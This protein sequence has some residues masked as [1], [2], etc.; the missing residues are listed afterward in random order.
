MLRR[1][2]ILLNFLLLFELSNACTTF[3]I[4]KNGQLVFGRNYD[5]ISGA[6]M[7][8]TNLRGLQ[9]TS[10]K[11]EDGATL[12]WISQYGSISFNQYGKEF[13]TG[14]MNEKGLVVELMWLDGT[15]YPSSDERPAVGTL[16]WIQYQLDC[17][18]TIEDVIASDRILRIASKGTVPLHFLIADANG[19]SATIEFLEGKMVVHKGKDLPFAVLTNDPYAESIQQTK[20]FTGQSYS[21]IDRFGRAC[22]KV[23]QYQLENIKIPVVDFAFTLLDNVAQ[24]DWTKWSIV[25]DINARKIYFKSLNAA[26]IKN[27]SFSSFDLACSASSKMLDINEALKGEVSGSFQ[28]FSIPGYRVVLEKA[29]RESQS[30]VMISE[31]SKKALL[32]YSLEINCK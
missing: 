28:K 26:A 25:Y 12:N 8:F 14:G 30:Q 11:T 15:V 7:I 27:I 3:F 18:E 32:N 5:W 9:K 1:L 13:P 16:Q 2:F 24:G 19:N 31:K 4:N 23:N 21:S 6:G 22:S 29:I 17:S 10:M 20:S